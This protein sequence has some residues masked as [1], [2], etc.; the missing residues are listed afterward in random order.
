[1]LAEALTVTNDKGRR[2]W[3]AKLHWLKG[4]SHL[5]RRAEHDR[6]AEARCRH[7]LDVTC[8]Q[9]A[10]SLELRAAMNLRRLWLR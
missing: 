5:A 4:E 1:M 10:K 7:A 9:Q 3:E 6:E 2:L 8:R